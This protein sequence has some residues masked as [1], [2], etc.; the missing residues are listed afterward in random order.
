LQ[1]W[2]PKIPSGSDAAM[3]KSKHEGLWRPFWGVVLAELCFEES[4]E[5]YFSN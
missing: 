1:T 5:E 4:F 2:D 3:A